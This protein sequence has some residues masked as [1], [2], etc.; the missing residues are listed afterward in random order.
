MLL[1]Q[2]VCLLTFC[3]MLLSIL[4]MAECR[5]SVSAKLVYYG[6]NGDC[7]PFSRCDLQLSVCLDRFSSS[8]WRCHYTSSRTTRKYSNQNSISFG[9]SEAFYV[10]SLQHWPSDIA[11]EVQVIDKDVRYDDFVDLFEHNLQQYSPTTGRNSHQKHM[12]NLRGNRG[13]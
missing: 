10:F 11:L 6:S 12:V 3:C 7:D 5:A 2:R 8:G 13:T 4:Q 1:S 9:S